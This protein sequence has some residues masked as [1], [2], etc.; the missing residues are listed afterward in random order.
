MANKRVIVR[1][2]L[3]VAA[4]IAFGIWSYQRTPMPSQQ[5]LQ[6]R[7]VVLFDVPRQPGEFQLTDYR[8]QAFGSDQLRGQWSLVFFGFTNCPGVCPMTLS[9]ISQRWDEVLAVEPDIR[10]LMISVDPARDTSARL[11]EYMQ[12]FHESFLGLTGPLEVLYRVSGQLM[13][14]FDPVSAERAGQESYMVSH[15]A[16]VQLVNPCGHHV[17]FLKNPLDENL[18]VKNIR[19]AIRF[20]TDCTS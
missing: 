9:T 19:D 5:Q 17:G 8:G 4:A 18:L 16:N 6:D 2:L 14:P 13:A 15:N 11:S 1:L 12:S 3:L 10:M 7:G 20:S